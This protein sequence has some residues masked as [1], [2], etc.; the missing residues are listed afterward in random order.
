MKA[1]ALL[2]DFGGVLVRIHFDRVFGHWAE[3]GGVPV[4]QVRSRFWAIDAYARHECGEI[5]LAEYFAALRRELPLDLADA[6][7]EEGWHRVFGDEIHEV[8]DV[9]RRLAGRVPQ[10]LFSNTNPS[11]LEHFT[12]RYAAALAP[13]RKLYASCGIGL[14][15]PGRAAFEY[16]SRDIGVPLERILFFDDTAENVE[17]ARAAGMQAVLVREP[18]DVVRAVAPWLETAPRA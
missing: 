12:R 15:K 14:R 2:Y 11:H 9:A 1:D 17:G 10:Y 6:E 13:F 7:F 18:H 3:R 8:V 4:E 5:G 16:I